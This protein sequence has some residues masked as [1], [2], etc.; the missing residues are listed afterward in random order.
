MIT[1]LMSLRCLSR[2]HF[3]RISII[4]RLGKSM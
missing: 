1:S 2:R 3:A 4:D